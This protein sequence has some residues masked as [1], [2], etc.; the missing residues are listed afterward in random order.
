MYPHQCR[1][2]T[3]NANLGPATCGPGAL[4]Y[5]SLSA[6]IQYTS[7]EANDGAPS[8]RT[9]LQMGIFVRLTGCKSRFDGTKRIHEHLAQCTT[10]RMQIIVQ[11]PAAV[12][13]PK[14]LPFAIRG[15]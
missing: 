14:F 13:L 7:Y 12:P 1:F 6:R 10:Y 4:P 15:A 5:H 9:Q 11:L 2:A 8:I 3:A